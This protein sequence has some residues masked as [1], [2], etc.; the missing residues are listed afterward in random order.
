MDDGPC[1]LADGTILT[2]FIRKILHRRGITDQEAIQSFLQPKLQDLPSPFLMKDMRQA[3]TIIERALHE[4]QEIIIWGD[5]D[6]DGTS[7]TALL[8]TFFESLGTGQ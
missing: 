8:F 7:A 5:Y 1:R 3:V 4:G 2:P 6:V